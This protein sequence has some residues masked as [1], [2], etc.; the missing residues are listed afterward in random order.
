MWMG[1]KAP[2]DSINLFPLQDYHHYSTCGRRREVSRLTSD[3]RKVRRPFQLERLLLAVLVPQ[4]M[5]GL[6][7]PSTSVRQH[8]NVHKDQ[9]TSVVPGV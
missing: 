1:G 4:Q 5:L 6:E 2:V 3:G 8:Q 7:G 9:S